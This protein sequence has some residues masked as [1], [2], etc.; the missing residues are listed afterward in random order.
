VL[1]DH[2]E[3]DIRQRRPL[4]E[5]LPVVVPLHLHHFAKR[6]AGALHRRERHPPLVQRGA[7]RDGAVLDGDGPVVV[8]LLGHPADQ[9]VHVADHVLEALLHLLGPLLEFVDEAVDLVD[10]QRRLHT[11]P[12]GLP[13]HRL[14]LGHRALDGVDNDQC[15]VDG[16]HRAGHVATEVDVARRVDEV[17][18]VVRPLVLV[19]H[20]HVRRVDGDPAFL[21]VLLCV[22]HQLGR[23]ALVGDHPGS[24]EEVVSQCRLPVID[25]RRD[26]DV[27][28][29]IRPVHQR[30]ALLYDLLS[31]AHWR[32]LLG[33]P[34]KG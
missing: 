30:L 25:V 14:R 10:E 11:L 18:E 8:L 22:H 33:A 20:R 19:C 21:F 4:V 34:S 24:S 31:S 15:A 17:D 32:L 3:H 12:Q 7:E 27:P 2:V 23:L 13:E 9:L 29:L 26:G 28:D 16:P 5:P 6:D 1:D